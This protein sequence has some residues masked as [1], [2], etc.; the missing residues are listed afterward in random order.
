MASGNYLI[1]DLC[2]MLKVKKE[3]TEKTVQEYRAGFLRKWRSRPIAQSVRV[4]RRQLR[5]VVKARYPSGGKGVVPVRA[6][7]QPPSL[8]YAG[9]E[10]PWLEEIRGQRERLR[11][12]RPACLKTAEG[13][14]QSSYQEILTEQIR[15]VLR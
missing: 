9:Y 7:L 10:G 12:M 11:E 14:S 2:R 8:R 15:A 1:Q 4:L 6:L 3:D 13:N 5:E